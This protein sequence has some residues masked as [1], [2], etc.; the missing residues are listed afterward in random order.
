MVMAVRLTES[1]TF[2]RDIEEIKLETFP[3]GHADT[4]IIP[5]ATAVVGRKIITNKK[6]SAGRSTYCAITPNTTGLGLKI[7]TLKCFGLMLSATP[8]MIKAMAIFIR[9]MLS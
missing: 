6:V 8:N 1:V 4:R 9:L 5:K 3:P 2:E 7:S